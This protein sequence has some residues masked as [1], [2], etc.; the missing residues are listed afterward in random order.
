[1]GVAA[2]D[3]DLKGCRGEEGRSRWE[4]WKGSLHGRRWVGGER[5][6]LSVDVE[7]G[8]L[9]GWLKRVVEED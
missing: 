5:R 3:V 6:R 8:G 2:D 4:W 1:M 7:G 9:E